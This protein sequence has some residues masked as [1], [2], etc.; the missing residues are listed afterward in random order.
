[1]SS[2]VL[3]AFLATELD[4]PDDNSPPAAAWALHQLAQEPR[5]LARQSWPGDHQPL[6]LFVRFSARIIA[7]LLDAPLKGRRR[8]DP[9]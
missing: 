6:H 9:L 7:F 4:H 3:C 8:R 1:V 5:G 2:A